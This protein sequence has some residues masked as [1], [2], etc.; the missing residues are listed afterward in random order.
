MSRMDRFIPYLPIGMHAVTGDRRTAVM[1]AADGTANYMCFP[2]YDGDSVFGALLDAERGGYWRL[3]LA[4][5]QAGH[6]NYLDHTSTL[7]TGW[8]TDTGNLEL[9]D[10]MPWPDEER[11]S[12]LKDKRILVRCLRCTYGSVKARMT[13]WPRHNFNQNYD[14]R[15][16]PGGLQFPPLTEGNGY[17]FWA[18][19]DYRIEDNQV[20]AELDMQAGDEVWAIFGLNE[21]PTE[22]S[23]ERARDVC[24]HTQHFWHSW[25]IDLNYSGM[26]A[27]RLEHSA[28]I[29]HML[30]YAPDG[31]MVAAPTTSLPERIGGN[32]NYDYRF[33]WV[34][35]AS[36]SIAGLT[37]M[38]DTD[39][40][41]RYLEWL[42]GLKSTDEMPLQVAYGIDG[43]TELSEN[44]RDDLTGFR[45]SPPVVSGNRAYDQLQLGALGYLADCAYL[46]VTHGGKW[47][48]KYWQLLER[49]ADF[50]M[51][52]WREP[53]NGIWELAAC[54][55]R[56]A[57]KVL[58]WVILDRTAKI[59]KI[60]GRLDNTEAYCKVRDEIF[61]DVMQNGWSE[62]RQ[63]FIQTYGKTSLDASTLLI[64]VLD[65]LPA[66]H[67]RVR[68]TVDRITEELVI[69]GLVYRFNPE[70][71]NVE[72]PLP[73]GQFE[74]AFLPCTFWL[75]TTY[76]KAGRTREAELTLQR[77]E[78]LLQDIGLFAEEADGRD[79]QLLGN[80]PL[81][82]S[83]V[84]YVRAVISLNAARLRWLTPT[85]T[86]PGAQG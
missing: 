62:E 18:S 31:S 64:P 84:E 30:G 36:L 65:F 12:E 69:D 37:L 19:F 52:H 21:D 23:V 58:C 11:P 15:E 83:Q 25:L 45:G 56:T 2:N 73:L 50:T 44:K 35:D 32:R 1:V 38:G 68:A 5:P 60:V 33:A 22:W 6:Q 57:S 3:G 51:R 75:A 79:N 7:L 8:E 43:R 27:R 74:G 9:Q 20:V 76:A 47:H 81:L 48:E 53:D 28:L 71:S 4:V 26:R 17:G 86:A 46:Y 40:A 49:V 24:Q 10:V 78:S 13:L 72:D 63:S 29:I 39:T 77:A 70:E 85:E 82:F 59:G 67:P 80:Y 34:R 16:V 54:E 14:I 42:S 55:Q 61:E 41:T 66:D